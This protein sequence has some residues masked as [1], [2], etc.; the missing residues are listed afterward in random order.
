M[1]DEG[2]VDLL[3]IK[4]YG[5]AVKIA[6]QSAVDNATALFERICLPAAGEFGLLL[7]DKFH[8]WRTNNLVAISEVA[9]N[10]LGASTDHAHPRL[11]SSIIE[12]GSWMDDSYVQDL[13]G[14]LLASSCTEDG[15]D[16]SN[17]MFIDLLSSITKSQARMLNYICINAEKYMSPEGLPAAKYFYISF[18]ILKEVSQI[19]DLIRIDRELDHLRGNEL[20]LGGFDFD[21]STTAIARV[22]PTAIAQNMYVRCQGSRKTP[23]EFF[24]LT[25]PE[26][27]L[28]K[29]D[30]QPLEEAI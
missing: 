30:E 21:Q 27:M 2:K 4:P 22:L 25:I 19:D 18:E 11:V 1:G 29:E 16:D 3:G 26:D 6:T 5:E 7:K 15:D 17:L 28:P 12:R 20:I 9:E 13:W 10:H 14:G 24:N 8:A 23:I